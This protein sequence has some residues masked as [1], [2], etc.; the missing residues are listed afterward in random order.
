[1][2]QTLQQI[3]ELGEFG[4]VPLQ[5]CRLKKTEYIRINEIKTVVVRLAGCPE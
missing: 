1:M 5:H 2:Q 3:I 4:F